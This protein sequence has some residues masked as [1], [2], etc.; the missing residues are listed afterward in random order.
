MM[1]DI[2][3]HFNLFNPTSDGSKYITTTF[4]VNTQKD[5]H[6]VCV[7]KVHSRLV[8]IFLNDFKTIIQHPS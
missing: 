2:H 6:I 8:S 4:N 5:I 7:Y 3:M 1:Y